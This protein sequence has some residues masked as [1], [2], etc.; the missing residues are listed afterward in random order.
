MSAHIK[1]NCFTFTWNIENISYCWQKTGEEISIIFVVKALEET[2]YK[3]NLYP[4]GLLDDN[5]ISF[6][7]HNQDAT[8]MMINCELAF[9]SKQGSIL[10][11]IEEENVT[12]MAG[13]DKFKVRNDVFVLN[14]S[15]YLPED[16]LTARCR[17]W[18][19]HGQMIEDVQCFARTR[20][21][22]ERESFLWN[23]RNFSRLQAE[24]QSPH[25]IRSVL[26]NEILMTLDIS[27]KN[28]YTEEDSINIRIVDEN[29]KIKYLVLH[30]TPLNGFGCE[31]KC[32][33]KEFLFCENIKIKLLSL[34]FSKI[35]LISKKDVC[36]PHDALSFRCECIFSTGTVFKEIE[37]VVYG[38]GNILTSEPCNHR[39][40][41][42]NTALAS[43]NVL[44]QNLNS[45]FHDNILSDIKLKT[46]TKTCF[47]HKNIL[48]VRSP[49][50]KVMFS[51]NMLETFNDSVH[52]EDLDSDTVYRMLQYIYTAEIKD[53]TWEDYCKLYRAADKYEILA[54]RN[55][56]SAYLK[57][58]L[59]PNNVCEVLILAD[60]HHDNDLKIYV[61]D[62][63]FEHNIVS[64][65]EWKCFMKT[66]LKLSADTMYVQVKKNRLINELRSP[67]HGFYANTLG[68]SYVSPSAN[69]VGTSCALPSSPACSGIGNNT[70]S[71]VGSSA[72]SGVPE[73]PGEEEHQDGRRR[74]V[75]RRSARH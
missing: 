15:I 49:V 48:S 75:A 13:S 36:L 19:R 68:T 67:A 52:I 39:L 29:S 61:Q 46:G 53:I 58:N 3:L 45:L 44:I 73:S 40:D 56:C 64:T 70:R 11:S 69:T 23:I 62:F 27:L 35:G 34:P 38:C 50:F 20:I 22:I 71:R 30:L 31:I 1:R 5:Y 54:L 74:K 10:A 9:L 51:N 4:R 7:L 47:A 14:R 21:C 63:I 6:Y 25:T 42:S 41:N 26:D 60:T 12:D 28:P 17:I 59:C 57:S 37:R 65:E 32:I 33:K 18:K 24:D 43:K 2:K 66:H 16:K 55:E 8:N 72:L